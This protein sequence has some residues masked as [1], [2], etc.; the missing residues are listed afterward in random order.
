MMGSSSSKAFE[1]ALRDM[2]ISRLRLDQVVMA[3]QRAFPAD[4]LSPDM[5]EHL[6]DAIAELC[7]TGV[8]S[9]PNEKKVN[10]TQASTLPTVIEMS[11]SARFMRTSSKALH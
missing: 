3:Y 11:A 2:G 1:A 8:V 6:H 10:E 7:R 5:R 9:I 4:S